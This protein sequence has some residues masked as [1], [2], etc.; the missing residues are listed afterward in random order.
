MSIYGSELLNEATAQWAPYFC[1]DPKL[2][3]F[4]HV[5]TAEPLA[6]RLMQDP[7]SG[8]DAA[9]ASQ[10]PDPA[11]TTPT[12]QAPV[13]ATG[14][15]I[16]Y[17][18]DNAKQK[19]VANLRLTP[20]LLAKLLTESYP[21]DKF[22]R[23]A[24]GQFGNRNPDGSAGSGIHDNP[25]NITEDPEFQA[26]NPG[27]HTDFGQA[28]PAALIVLSAESDVT[29]ALTRYINADPEARAWLDG[30]PDPWGMV[31]NHNYVGIKLPLLRWPLLDTTLPDFA[32][33]VPCAEKGED[34]APWLPLVESP[35]PDLATS[36]VDVQFASSPGKSVCS[37]T[38]DINDPSS[39]L[40][41]WVSAGRMQPGYRFVVGRHLAR[42]GAT[43]RPADRGPAE[44]FVGHR[45]REAVLQRVRAAPS[46]SPP[47]RRCR[48]AAGHVTKNVAD[49][50][51]A[52]D[53]S[54]LQA[55]KRA[56]PGFMLVDADIPTS[57]LARAQRTD[58]ANFLAFA[59]KRGQV[60]G[61]G[62]GDL[63]PRLPAADARERTRRPR[64]LHRARG[65]RG[66][67]AERPGA[68]AR[69]PTRDE[70][71]RPRPR[72]R[73]RPVPPAAAA[74]WAVARTQAEVPAPAFRRPPRPT[75]PAAATSGAPSPRTSGA[76]PVVAV[77]SGPPKNGIGGVGLIL[78]I[79]LGV[80]ALGGL[81]ACGA[82]YQPR[83]TR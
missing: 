16:S 79:I 36:T 69:R 19:P 31:V 7:T 47:S 27:I 72:L 81:L 59:A 55:D 53:P 17:T 82:A 30:K 44:Q 1:L 50:L 5:Q 60:S 45:L 29:Y 73:Q 43:L 52:V 28:G 51:F 41:Q 70:S 58:Y 23:F 64:G 75:A 57:G 40:Y 39:Q 66:P 32:H 62:N 80:A 10:P 12:V 68:A 3:K 46:S 48:A 35:T 33:Q 76:T 4:T 38:G 15:S 2:F 56:Y 24:P 71:R 54:G 25:V 26:L 63:P 34:P 65:H 49:K 6:Q 9:F 21:G 78:P 74:P 77:A 22:D 67:D 37:L 8:V 42:R 13:A 61:L 83:R 18:I 14:F 20:R 11:F